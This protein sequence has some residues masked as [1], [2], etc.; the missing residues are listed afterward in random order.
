MLEN[1]LEIFWWYIR[2]PVI[3]ISCSVMSSDFLHKFYMFLLYLYA[4]FSH[5]ESILLVG[6][7][8]CHKNLLSDV[9]E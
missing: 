3:H 9:N 7:P 5:V 2:L 6:I 8:A 1:E 4:C